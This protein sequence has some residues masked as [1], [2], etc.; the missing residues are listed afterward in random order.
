MIPLSLYSSRIYT[1]PR[2]LFWLR[3]VYIGSSSLG[4]AEMLRAPRNPRDHH[5]EATQSFAKFLYFS[6]RVGIQLNKQN[7]VKQSNWR[8][9]ASD[10]WHF[11][12]CFPTLFMELKFSL[13]FSNLIKD[14]FFFPSWW[15]ET[16]GEE[17]D[18]IVCKRK[19]ERS[20]IYLSALWQI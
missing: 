13:T 10:E 20:H 12:S 3:M 14:C 18:G 7:K 5:P 4:F 8:L 2:V 17:T 15:G 11:F 16:G 1:A 19:A 9:W 6:L